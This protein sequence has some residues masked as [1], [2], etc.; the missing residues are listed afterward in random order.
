MQMLVTV[1]FENLLISKLLIFIL[2]CFAC[3]C[4]FEIVKLKLMILFRTCMLTYVVQIT[5]GFVTGWTLIMASCSGN[6]YSTLTLLVSTENVCSD[7][8]SV[9]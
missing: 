5:P 1:I 3:T 7:E 2:R 8:S 6:I 4:C 9:L